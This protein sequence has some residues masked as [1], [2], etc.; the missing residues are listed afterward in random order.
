MTKKLHILLLIIFLFITK[1]KTSKN[2]RNL[3]A[4]SL[5]YSNAEHLSYADPKLTFDITIGVPTGLN[6]GDYQL[7]ILIKNEKKAATCKYNSA[8]S[9]TK[10]NCEC[11]LTEV[12]YG[13]IQLPINSEALETD[14]ISLNLESA[15]TLQQEVE[16]EYQEANIEFFSS[17]SPAYYKL[18]ITLQQEIPTTAFYQVDIKI[19]ENEKVVD[20]VSSSAYLICDNIRGEKNN[21][22]KLL[23]ERKDG[24]VKWIF[25]GA[26]NFD[27]TQFLKF[28]IKNIYAYDLKFEDDKW[29]FK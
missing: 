1:T 7:T 14:D 3:Q 16:L 25:T 19:D 22:I 6:D 2:L 12:Y 5:T 13:S 24:S 4:I 26:E 27:K 8:E 20:C 10:L 28:E 9:T 18:K 11:T 17:G 29:K 15:I 23:R 21:L